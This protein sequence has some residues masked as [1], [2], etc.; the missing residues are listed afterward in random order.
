VPFTVPRHAARSL[1]GTPSSADLCSHQGRWFLQVGMRLP[2]PEVPDGG[3]VAV[4]GM[5]LGLAHPAVPSANRLLGERGWRE[6]EQRIF[7]LRRGLQAKGPRSAK[8][9]RKQLSGKQLRHRSDHDHVLAKRIVESVAAGTTIVL[10]HLR[11]ITERTEQQGR[12]SRR[13]HH[14][15]SF[16]PFHGLVAYKA[17]E[18]GMRVVKVD[19]R[20]TSQTCSRWG[21][22]HG[23]NRRSQSL[24]HC[25]ACGFHCNA[26]LNAARN[27]RNKHRVSLGIPVSGGPLSDG[28]SSQSVIGLQASPRL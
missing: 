28:L 3:E 4:V 16:H 5:D 20:Q 23:L 27:V 7:R 12:A 25:R 26:D 18:R 15:W 1:S 6:H 17:E 8:R 22:Q 11:G 19:P 10:E 2:T 14:A 9:H 21:F 24:L 13:R